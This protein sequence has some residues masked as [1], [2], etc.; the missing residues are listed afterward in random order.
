MEEEKKVGSVVFLSC[1][2]SAGQ[3]RTDLPQSL[4]HRNVLSAP[5]PSPAWV[6][7][8]RPQDVQTGVSVRSEVQGPRAKLHRHHFVTGL[9][10]D[11]NIQSKLPNRK[12]CF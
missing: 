4:L 1:W 10:L 2:T 8:G 7:W 11:T 9:K 3:N 12:V 5:P 6:Q